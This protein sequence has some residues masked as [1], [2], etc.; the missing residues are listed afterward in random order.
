[1]LLLTFVA[2]TAQALAGSDPL[3]PAREGLVQ[4]YGVHA[5]RKT[6]DGIGVYSFGPDGVV[7]NN[8]V[9]MMLAE[10]RVLLRASSKV[11]VR[12]AAECSMVTDHAGMITALEVDGVALEGEQFESLRQ[13]FASELKASLGSGE[14]C[15]TYQPGPDSM[16]RSVVTVNGVEMP[17]VEN[18]TLWV[19]P[20]D[21]WRVAP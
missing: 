8:S 11:Y 18:T 7:T 4:C 21:G 5:E 2:L 15:T 19:H 3:A 14:Y 6:C 9:N 13:H 1:M 17:Q 20:S 16:L 12:G 10:P